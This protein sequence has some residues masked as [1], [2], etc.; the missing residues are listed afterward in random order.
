MNAD[1][2]AIYC[3]ICMQPD[4]TVPRMMFADY[5]SEFGK[6]PLPSLHCPL[7]FHT[8][9]DRCFKC[10]GSRKQETIAHNGFSFALVTLSGYVYRDA[11]CTPTEWGIHIVTTTPISEIYLVDRQIAIPVKAARQVAKEL[12]EYVRQMD[13]RNAHGATAQRGTSV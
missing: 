7:C 8:P 6:Q 1:A 9:T 5:E 2:L 10:N 12:R 3:A 11:D 4:A 13:S